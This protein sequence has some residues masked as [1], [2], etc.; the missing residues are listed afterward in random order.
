MQRI[1]LLE[2]AWMEM[3]GKGSEIVFQLNG[4]EINDSREKLELVLNQKG[5]EYRVEQPFEAEINKKQYFSEG[6]RYNV[7]DD[8]VVGLALEYL[9]ISRDYIE[10]HLGMPDNTTILLGQVY[11]MYDFEI[12]GYI[13]E[14]KKLDLEITFDVEQTFARTFNIG[15]TLY[16]LDSY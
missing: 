10:N 13:W 6:C 4:I 5:V 12:D 14:Y 11:S 16:F 15:K 9:H 1:E 7:I 2:S 3:V 8:K